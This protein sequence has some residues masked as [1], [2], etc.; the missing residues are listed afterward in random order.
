M[1]VALLSPTLPPSSSG[2]ALVIQRILRE[3]HPDD[4]CLISSERYNDANPGP[5]ERLEANYYHLPPALRINKGHR[6]GLQHLRE[7]MNIPLAVWQHSRLLTRII[8]HERCEAIVACTGDVPLLPAAYLASR[9][10]RV[11][12]YAWI[13]DHYSYRE[14][15]DPAASF[16]ARRL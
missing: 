9:R 11:P 2:Q 13:F 6:F 15:A 16:W 14:W 1:K 7:G 10:A 4:Y 12:F 8:K 3:F 5:T